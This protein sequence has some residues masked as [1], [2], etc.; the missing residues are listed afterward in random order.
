MIRHPVLEYVPFSND[1]SC[2]FVASRIHYIYDWKYPSNTFSFVT[3]AVHSWMWQWAL[4][5]DIDKFCWVNYE[6]V[7]FYVSS[8]W[9]SCA[10]KQLPCRF[11][12]APCFS[13]TKY[14]T[15]YPTT[16]SSLFSSMVFLLFAAAAAAAS[17]PMTFKPVS[18]VIFSMIPLSSNSLFNSKAWDAAMLSAF[19]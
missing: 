14:A 15:P 13:S 10:S 6:S 3:A 1:L 5:V 4:N 9:C 2:Y 16:Q 12:I 7:N 18:S 8:D 17:F 19:W 11:D